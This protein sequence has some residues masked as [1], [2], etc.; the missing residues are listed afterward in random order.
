MQ[1]IT[2]EEIL[3]IKEQLGRPAEGLKE[4][5]Y[6]N[7]NL[8]PVVL[9]VTSIVRGRPFP[10]MYWLS[11][12]SLCKEIDKIESHGFIKELEN[13]IIPE[14]SKLKAKIDQDHHL[15]I[16]KRWSYFLLEHD[17]KNVLPVYQQSLKSKGIGGLSKFDRVRCLHMHYAHYLADDNAIGALLEDKFNLK[18][19]IS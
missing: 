9:R 10:N 14:D 16:E 2:Q 7:S 13:V 1:D 15:Y 12:K 17:L 19:Y 11:D 6:R 5:V 8:L 18:Q 3:F 4:I